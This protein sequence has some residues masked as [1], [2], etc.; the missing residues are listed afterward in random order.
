MKCGI[1]FIDF[2]AEPSGLIGEFIV[3]TSLHFLGVVFSFSQAVFGSKWTP[4]IMKFLK[5]KIIFRWQ[6]H[7]FSTAAAC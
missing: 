5:Q 2:K 6:F 3:L 1:T 4:G 7:E